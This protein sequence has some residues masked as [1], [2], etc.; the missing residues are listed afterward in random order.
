[1]QEVI[2]ELQLDLPKACM[3][4]EDF[5]RKIL[6]KMNKDGAVVG[7]SGGLDSAVTAT[8]TVRSLGKEN[9]HL[10][11]MPERDS[12]P[13][14]KRHAKELANFLGVKLR[15]KSITPIV[16]AV[17]GYKL[18]PIRFIPSRRLRGLLV[19]YG[20]SKLISKEESNLLENRLQPKAG[21]WIARGNAYLV[22]KHRT[23]MIVLYQYA[24]VN[25]LMVVGAANRTEWLTGTFTKWGIDH[26]SDMMPLLHIYRS[27]L[28]Q[29][30]E[31]L[32]IPDCIR[33]KY[34]DPDIIPGI[35]NKEELLGSFTLVDQV[36]VASENGQPVSEL[37]DVYGQKNVE[38]VLTLK[39]LSA[40]M[41]ES[42]YHILAR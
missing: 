34:A 38:K 41:R 21:S 36:L 16:R 33:L 17:K 30:A 6:Q 28:E 23:R 18:L 11:N 10:F 8:L 14:H 20:R 19:K 15:K 35:D 27:Q 40:Q 31:Y 26:C 2:K 24:D 25:N 3:D 29:I 9:V 4:I 13:I 1:M 32:E 37:Y 5:I 22:T 7:V 12:K 42:P 39:K